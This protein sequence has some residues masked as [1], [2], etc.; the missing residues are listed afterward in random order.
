MNYR[1]INDYEVL[2]MV[3][4]NDEV[5]LNLLFDK[6][7]PIVLSLVKRFYKKGKKLGLDY[8]DLIQEANIGL[9]KAIRNFKQSNNTLFY[10]FA[11]LCVERELS[12]CIKRNDR[13]KNY[14]L[15]YSVS[16]DAKILDQDL[17]ISDIIV[18][19]DNLGPDEAVLIDE[20]LTKT[21]HFKN[22][23]LPFQACVFELRYNGFSYKEIATLLDVKC[24]DVDNALYRI[25]NKLNKLVI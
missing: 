17:C 11:S 3:S 13:I 12:L 8:Q 15:N 20:I 23:L 1:D 7:R 14:S 9:M 4:D 25:K 19:E 2:Y 21:I 5:A 10:T 18:D 22:S 16:L 24:K 6:Y